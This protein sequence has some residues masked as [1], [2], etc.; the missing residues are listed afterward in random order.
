MVDP[1]D[2]NETVLTA[3]VGLV[4]WLVGLDL[5]DDFGVVLALSETSSAGFLRS[6]L[7]VETPLAIVLRLTTALGEGTGECLGAEV[8][9]GTAEDLAPREGEPRGLPRRCLESLCLPPML[10]LS[11]DAVSKAL[12]YMD[13]DDE[14]AAAAVFSVDTPATL[15]PDRAALRPTT[16][17]PRA[18]MLAV[19]D[20]GMGRPLFLG[21]A[22]T[23][24]VDT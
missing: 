13:E 8:T 9:A 2:T 12:L 21:L 6:T 23:S 14:E 1:A 16:S 15:P 3:L 22:V 11:P 10:A 7:V 5:L 4:I 20:V 18:A 19:E 24:E 17:S